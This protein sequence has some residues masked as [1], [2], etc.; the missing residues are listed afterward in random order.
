MSVIKSPNHNV[1]TYNLGPS[2]LSMSVSCS[3]SIKQSLAFREKKILFLL[4]HI[5]NISP[6]PVLPWMMA[7]GP[8]ATSPLLPNPQA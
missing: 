2:V 8:S 3:Y 1:L 5:E 4:F 6:S 7:V